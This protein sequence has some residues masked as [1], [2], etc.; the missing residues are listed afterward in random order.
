MRLVS[1]LGA[2]VVTAYHRHP[3]LRQTAADFS[4]DD[5]FLPSMNPALELSEASFVFAHDA[6]TGYIQPNH[7]SPEGLTWSYT[8]TQVGSF[9]QQLQDGARALDLRPKLWRN[10]TIVFHH[11]AITVPVNFESAL[12]EVL[13]WCQENPTEIVLLLTS[14]YSFGRAHQTS[15]DDDVVDIYDEVYDDDDDDDAVY[16]Q[17]DK[18]TAMVSALKE[19]YDK[20]GVLYLSCGDVYGWT[21]ETVEEQASLTNGGIVLALDGQDTYP[22]KSC[23]KD[24]WLES[25]LVTCWANGTSCKTSDVPYERLQDYV[26]QSANNAA[27]DGTN[28]LGPPTNLYR[29]PFF[30]VQALWQVTVSSA[31]S[32]LAHFSNILADNKASELHVKLIDLIHR[33][34]MPGA[35]S[36]WTVDNVALHGNAL[37]SV[38][39]NRCGQSVLT[40]APCGPDLPPP[41]LHYWH[42]EVRLILSL[43]LGLYVTFLTVSFFRKRPHLLRASAKLC[44][45]RWR[46]YKGGPATDAS[47]GSDKGDALMSPNP[48]AVLV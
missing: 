10:G 13:R 47:T 24:N 12:G 21:I 3:C 45:Q 40:D 38:L 28:T 1:L 44:Y 46:L 32:G 41:R 19:I 16:D 6:A 29:Y 11:G 5:C 25:E 30:E 35:I 18:N 14:H 26:L 36:L 42:V 9:Y 27:T 31:A 8:K 39:R 15:G 48:T 20:H 22:E 43:M 34:S 17:S 4:F 23:A 37:M 2:T 33:E 7:L